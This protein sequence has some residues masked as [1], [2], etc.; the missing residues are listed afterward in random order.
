M[1]WKPVVSKAIDVILHTNLKNVKALFAVLFYFYCA[2]LIE[3]QA[4]ACPR[5]CWS[6]YA[7][8]WQCGGDALQK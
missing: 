8:D 6:R 7:N 2:S 4:S 5:K 3:P 1:H